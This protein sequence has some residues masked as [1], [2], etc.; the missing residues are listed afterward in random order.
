M[1]NKKLFKQSDPDLWLSTFDLEYRTIF[2]GNIFL[3]MSQRFFIVL[4]QWDLC[5]PER[6]GCV[7]NI[8]V[9]DNEC[10]NSCEGLYITGFERRKF[11]KDKLE[12]LLSKV[13]ED[14]ELYKAGGIMKYSNNMGGK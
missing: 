12:A 14:Y 4:F 3:M 11:N 10:L 8:S 7:K 2:R 9:T 6:L 13:E 5:P 1:F